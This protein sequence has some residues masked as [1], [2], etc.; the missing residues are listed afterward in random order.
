MSFRT[1][2]SAVHSISRRGRNLEVQEHFGASS[3][4]LSIRMGAPKLSEQEAHRMDKLQK[5]GK[6]ASRILQALRAQRRRAS[7][8][9][10]GK[11]AVHNFLSGQTHQRGAVETRG[12]KTKVP[13]SMIKAASAQRRKLIK[14]AGN[15][16]VVTWEDVHKATK[17]T[18]RSSGVLVRASRWQYRVRVNGCD[19]IFRTG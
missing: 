15:Q 7:S 1:V 17:K 9:G 11:S 12:R 19:H 16:Y 3:R 2:G 14:A 8:H 10:P 6:N 18:L 13:P 5:E 4:E